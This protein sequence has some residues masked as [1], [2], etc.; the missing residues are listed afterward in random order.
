MAEFKRPSL[1]SGVAYRDPKA[2]L[3]WLEEAFGFEPI[4]VVV[5]EDGSIGHSEMRLGNGMIFVG[6]E[7]DDNHRSPASLG[8]KNTQSIHVQLD[9][10]IDA[11]C[12]R[13]RKAGAVITR[14]PTDQFYGDRGYAAVDPEGHAWTFAQT[15]HAMSHEDMAKAGGVEIRD[16]L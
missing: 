13:A 16:R 11:H 14:E 6:S 1:T 9:A 3:K 15:I 12:E 5:N 8:G 2:A 10:G 7:W 4:M